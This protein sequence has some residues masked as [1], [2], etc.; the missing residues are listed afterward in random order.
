MKRIDEKRR[1]LEGQGQLRLNL[2]C[3]QR[4]HPQW[5]NLDI[6]AESREVIA[7]DLRRGIPLPNACC[8]AVYHCAVLEHL[9]PAE[10]EFFLRECRRVM[11]KGAIL[12]VGVPDLE[13]ITRLYLQKLDAARAGD[14]AA[15]A[16]REWLCLELFDQLAR[17]QSGGEMMKFLQRDPLPAED[18]ILARIGE[19]G[20]QILD[21]IRGASPGVKRS[22]VRRV[23]G[24]I[25]R[26]LRSPSTLFLSKSD[27]QA[28]EIGRFRLLGE[29]HQWMYD[30]RSLSQLLLECELQNVVRFDAHGSQ[31]P[32]FAR[33]ELDVKQGKVN[34][35]DCFFLE[36]TAQ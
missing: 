35:P 30:E 21:G 5:L 12:R 20:R 24:K 3:G 16:E 13:G 27:R 18:F 17:E 9:R 2:G 34:K 25:R 8:D 26:S 7:V 11:K 31:I 33:F 10:A 36:A 28:L 23:I 14:V 4:F 32:D 22:L 15:V 6:I 29:A 19:E 1:E